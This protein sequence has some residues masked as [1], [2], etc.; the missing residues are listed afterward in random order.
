M[1]SGGAENNPPGPASRGPDFI[2]F[3]PDATLHRTVAKL[4]FL[5]ETE[6]LKEVLRRNY[7][8][9]GKRL[10]N[11]AEHSWHVAL[12]AVL[13]FEDAAEP[14]VDLLRVLK[15]LLIHDLVEIDAGDTYAFDTAA[16]ADKVEREEQAA[17]RIFGLLPSDLGNELRRLWAEFDA[18][19][20]PDARFAL[21]LDRIQPAIQNYLFE[22]TVWKRNKVDVDRVRKRFDPIRGAIPPLERLADLMLDDAVRR[23][24]FL[25]K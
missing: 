1:S 21:A 9:A 3:A 7:I 23:G 22:G 19:E 6:K 11:D 2:S 12:M 4:E 25:E 17:D 18:G 10:E 24:F 20:T 13:F 8:L 16:H 14:G 15:M 5:R